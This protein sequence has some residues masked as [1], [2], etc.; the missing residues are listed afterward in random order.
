MFVPDV[1]SVYSRTFPREMLK[2][3]TAK[4][5]DEFYNRDRSAA[6]VGAGRPAAAA[7]DDKKHKK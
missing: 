5:L 4:T 1:L 6:G 2:N 3:I 7:A